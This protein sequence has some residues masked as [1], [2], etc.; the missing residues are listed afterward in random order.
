MLENHLLLITVFTT[1]VQMKSVQFAES[2]F[3]A[4]NDIGMSPTDHDGGFSCVCV[5]VCVCLPLLFLG[6]EVRHER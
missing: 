2:I 5:C 3:F 1:A 6:M 4:S